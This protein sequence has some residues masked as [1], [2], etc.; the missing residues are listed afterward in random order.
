MNLT[1]WKL[2]QR[3]LPLPILQSMPAGERARNR[4][5]PLHE[6]QCLHG[7][8]PFIP[9]MPGKMLWGQLPNLP[10]V[11]LHIQQSRE[12]PSVRP[13]DAFNVLPSTGSSHH[14]WISR[15]IA[16]LHQK[17]LLIWWSPWF[18]F[19]QEYTCSHYTCPICSKSLGN[20]QV[21]G[22]NYI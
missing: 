11:H 15:L 21:C 10:W 1:L 4:L 17:F 9:Y 18:C 19:F 6:L 12:G 8:F 2:K 16:C 5:L 3:N 7:S 13:P 20:M 14:S 22:S